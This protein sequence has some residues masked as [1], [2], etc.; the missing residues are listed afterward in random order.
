MKIVIVSC[1]FDPEPVVSSKTSQDLAEYLSNKENEVVVIT[2][3]PSRGVTPNCERSYVR[4]A[5][6]F[7][8]GYKIIRCPTWFSFRSQMLSRFLENLSFGLT[9]SIRL[10]VEKEVD[11]V[12]I[13]TWPIF[14]VFITCLVSKF[15]STKV[16]LSVQDVYP[17]SII[18]QRKLSMNGLLAR[19]LRRID[20]L[21]IKIADSVVVISKTFRNIYELNRK[22]SLEKFS[23]IPN[24]IEVNDVQVDVSSVLLKEQLQLQA[25]SFVLTYAGNIGVGANVEQLIDN[26]K[27]LDD[28]I[29]WQLLI[30]GSGSQLDI[31]RKKAAEFIQDRV[32]FRSPWAREDTASV[33]GASDVLLLPTDNQ[34]SMASMPSKLLYYMAAGKPV[35]AIADLNSE[36]ANVIFEARC[37]WVI[38]K[39]SEFTETIEEVF[40][41]DSNNLVQIGLNG[42][43]YVN[44]N[45]SKKSC[46]KKIAKIINE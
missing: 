11:V 31:C 23:Y 19:I 18:S 35:V 5:E 28:K 24:W 3:F 14:A 22:V 46:L 16:I 6:D 33:L 4:W 38:D 13:N 44:E 9:S 21:N 2:A 12:Y 10:L 40:R 17:E 1:V 7:T 20:T 41:I 32:V 25:K 27:H 30:A 15:K 45:F 26:F 34:Q 29:Q 36:L 43:K 37:G 39:Y 8:K 42:K